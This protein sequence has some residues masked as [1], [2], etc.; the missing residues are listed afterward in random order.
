MSRFHTLDSHT[1]E[2]ILESNIDPRARTSRP[3]R[4][5]TK[6]GP[7]THFDEATLTALVVAGL[8][9]GLAFMS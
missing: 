4:R 1:G 5:I 8:I 6:S 3:G 2:I 7:V 9:V